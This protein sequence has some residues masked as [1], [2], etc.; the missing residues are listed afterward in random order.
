MNDE[1]AINYDRFGIQNRFLPKQPSSSVDATAASLHDGIDTAPLRALEKGN[2]RIENYSHARYMLSLWCYSRGLIEEQDLFPPDVLFTE[3][4]EEE[5]DTDADSREISLFSLSVGELITELNK[6]KAAEEKLYT[7]NTEPMPEPPA[8]LFHRKMKAMD[9]IAAVLSPSSCAPLPDK[10]EWISTAE[11]MIYKVDERFA[12]SVLKPMIAMVREGSIPCEGPP[13]ARLAEYIEKYGET[14]SE[15]RRAH[16]RRRVNISSSSSSSSHPSCPATK[17][18]DSL[19]ARFDGLDPSKGIR[20]IEPYMKSMDAPVYVSL[21]RRTR[22]YTSISDIDWQESVSCVADVVSIAERF[23]DDAGALMPD[24]AGARL[25]RRITRSLGS[26]ALGSLECDLLW[27][28]DVAREVLTRLFILRPEAGIPAPVMR[29]LYTLCPYFLGGKNSRV[30]ISAVMLVGT[31]YISYYGLGSECVR[32]VTNGPSFASTVSENTRRILGA[33]GLHILPLLNRDTQQFKLMAEKTLMWI[34]HFRNADL[35]I[36]RNK[37]R[38]AR[39][40]QHFVFFLSFLPPYTSS[41]LVETALAKY[42]NR[43][44]MMLDELTRI[45][46]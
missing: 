17:Y 13:P 18:I 37:G 36:K 29:M 23:N 2:Y 24:I 30:Y 33:D 8:T 44:R 26:G 34:F 19:I 27:N 11:D 5:D 46:M 32:L 45:A 4:E 39:A 22:E 21:L 40:W 43:S 16:Y 28:S 3:G 6:I 42:G 12:N 14:D 7:R 25:I 38:L 31:K 9:H 41:A 10:E 35:G 20:D 1:D 15:R